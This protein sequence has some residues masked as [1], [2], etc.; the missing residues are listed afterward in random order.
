M[1]SA[2]FWNAAAALAEAK[3][4]FVVVTL[5]NIK[6]HA[7]QDLGAKAIVTTDGLH[8]GT[9]GGG[10]VEAR[11]IELAQAMISNRQSAPRLENWNLQR[12]IGMT[13]GGEASYLF[14][15]QLCASWK[16]AIFGAGH[17]SQALTRLL[18]TLNCEVSCVDSRPEWL[19]KLPA[20][21]KVT[22]HRVHE[23]R[24]AVSAFD[25]NTFFLVMTSGHATDLP[26]LEEIF[27]KFP[28][29]PFIGLIGSPTKAIKIR[30]DLKASG[31]V[32]ELV[33]KLRCPVGLP[34]GGSDP[35][36]IAVSIAAELIGVRD[37][38]SARPVR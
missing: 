2:E 22:Q 14:E 35:A 6:G 33:E 24:S 19:E 38:E 21:G 7:P 26:V 1:K 15:P 12:D 4:A 8:W 3:K 18:V 34:I 5:V 27:R 13:C 20:H 16:I 25:E 23:L 9:V 37:R 30:A 17:V 32:S 36:E 10:K 28:G 11:A 29:A 31:I